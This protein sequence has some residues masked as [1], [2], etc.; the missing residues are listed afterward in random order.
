MEYTGNIYKRHGKDAPPIPLGGAHSQIKLVLILEKKGGRANSWQRTVRQGPR[1]PE[2]S[3]VVFAT[4]TLNSSSCGVEARNQNRPFF[5]FFFLTDTVYR[6]CCL[7]H[8]C[9][10]FSLKKKKKVK[11]VKPKTHIFQYS[12]IFLVSFT[13]VDISHVHNV[14][15]QVYK[16][17][18]TDCQ[19]RR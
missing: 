18:P 10:F 2:C 3:M 1:Y 6:G 8:S 12:P 17:R 13:S 4:R 5:F 9:N 19:K 11:H 16:R 15:G 14:L 7:F